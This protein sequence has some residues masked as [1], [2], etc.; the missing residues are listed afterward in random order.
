MIQLAKGA[1]SRQRRL[2]LN[3]YSKHL[4]ALLTHLESCYGHDKERHPF[5][6]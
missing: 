6:S 3:S 2:T 5:T 1:Y 4:Q